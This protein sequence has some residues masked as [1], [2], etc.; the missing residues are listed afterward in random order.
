M[1]KSFDQRSEFSEYEWH[2]IA[3]LEPGCNI[4]SD[5]IKRS[6]PTLIFK[7]TESHYIAKPCVWY[8]SLLKEAGNEVEL[9]LVEG[10]NHFFSSNGSI[11]KGI[12]VNG[13]FDNPVI[14]KSRRDF[15]FSDGIPTTREE[16]KIKCMTQQGGAGKDRKYL[17]SV[18]N[19]VLDFF[20]KHLI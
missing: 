8:T 2:A 1:L 11:V 3:S 18:V 10:G 4:V 6:F 12:A 7:G 16:V 13:C 19:Q 15:L 14:R 20:D 9:R 5:P 17:N